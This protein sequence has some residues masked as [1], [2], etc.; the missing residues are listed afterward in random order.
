[1]VA[2]TRDIDE[3]DDDDGSDNNDIDNDDEDFENDLKSWR[4]IGA[5]E[6]GLFAISYST[7]AGRAKMDVFLVV[8]RYEKAGW[9]EVKAS[10]NV[11]DSKNRM[12]RVIPVP[13]TGTSDGTKSTQPPPAYEE[14]PPAVQPTV[15]PELPNNFIWVIQNSNGEFLCKYGDPIFAVTDRANGTQFGIR[16]TT[17][18]RFTMSCEKV[19]VMATSYSASGG[20]STSAAPPYRTQ[21]V[22]ERYDAGSF[23]ICLANNTQLV[24]TSV[25][26]GSSWKIAKLMP[27]SKDDTCQRWL[28]T[29]QGMMNSDTITWLSEASTI[30]L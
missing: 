29:F 2:L 1:M 22:L 26:S 18:N 7:G 8:N 28:L 27:K 12:W 24:I 16:Y 9:I 6:K 14:K 15:F 5:K 20:I 10:N 30:P 11:P 17:G 4:V 23:F 21:W 3:S 13:D 19:Y 25:D